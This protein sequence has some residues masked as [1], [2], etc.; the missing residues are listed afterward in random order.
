M[1]PA[2]HGFCTNLAPGLLGRCLMAA[3]GGGRVGGMQKFSPTQ[4][5]RSQTAPQ[6]PPKPLDRPAKTAP[7]T[8]PPARVRRFDDVF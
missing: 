2:L 6:P 8:R 5:A 4:H 7:E 3:R 1:S